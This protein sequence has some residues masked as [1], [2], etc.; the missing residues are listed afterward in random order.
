MSALSVAWQQ[1]LLVYHHSKGEREQKLN[2]KTWRDGKSVIKQRVRHK[3]RKMH[4]R[5]K[6]PQMLCDS[7]R[8]YF[9]SFLI[10]VWRNE[11]DCSSAGNRDNSVISNAPSAAESHDEQR[12]PGRPHSPRPHD[13]VWAKRASD[14]DSSQD[15]PK[16]S[17]PIT[18]FKS[19]DLQQ[20]EL[21]Q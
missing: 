16:E 13:S 1:Q 8:Y 20:N 3:E 5:K 9:L 14:R 18:I 2:V 17:Q 11:A 6:N 10:M 19:C 21:I 15:H 4:L 12:I 7:F